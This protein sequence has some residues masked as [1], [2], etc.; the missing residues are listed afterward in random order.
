MAT[1]KSLLQTNTARDATLAEAEAL[2]RQNQRLKRLVAEL[3][4]ALVLA[5]AAQVSPGP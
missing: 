2:Q 4:P 1:G 5:S 3:F